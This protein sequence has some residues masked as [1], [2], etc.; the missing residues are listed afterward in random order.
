MKT[1]IPP[2]LLS[3]LQTHREYQRADLF[4]ILLGNG[5]A[6]TATDWQLDVLNAGAP[7][8]TYYATKYGRW[9]RSPITSEAT[10]SCASNTMT[11]TVT[12]PNDQTVFFP[13][14]NTPLFETVSTGL[15]DKATVWVY[16]AYSPLNDLAPNISPNGFD[17][18]LGL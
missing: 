13:G 11:L 3:F 2:P 15:F 1:S 5:Q 8:L 12:I 6:I 4:L 14:T 9:K 10:F 18:S 17:T 16:T 7:P